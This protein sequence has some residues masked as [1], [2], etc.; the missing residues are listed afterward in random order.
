MTQDLNT[1]LTAL[2]VK[3]DDE[4]GGTRCMGRPPLLSD[5]EL[6]CLAVAQALLGHHSE[7]RWLR[8]ARKYLSGMF[9]YLPQQSGYNKRL[10]AALPLIKRMIRELAIDSDFWFDNH[11]IVDSTPV[12]CGMSR[13]TVQ[14]SNLAGW[15]GYGYCASHSRFFWGLRLYL[16]CTPTGMPILW[17]LA[18]PK[19]GEREVLAA[20]LE[21]D[22]DLVAT[23][24]GILLISDKGFAS[25]SF[26]KDL[27]ASGQGL[28]G[29]GM[30]F[31][32][33]RASAVQR[34]AV[35]ALAVPG[36]SA[37]VTVTVTVTTSASM[38]TAVLR[39][40]MP[41]GHADQSALNAPIGN[42]SRSARRERQSLV[43]AQMPGEE[44]Q[45]TVGLEGRHIPVLAGIGVQ[46]LLS[47]GQGVEQ[48][49]G[50]LA[51]HPLIVPLHQEL[52]RDGDP[53]GALGRRQRRPVQP[54]YRR[55]DPRL[56]GNQRNAESAAQRHAPVTHGAQIPERVQDRAP[57]RD[58]LGGQ[59]RV[60]LGQQRDRVARAG[61]AGPHL[62]DDP[63]VFGGLGP[64]AVGWGVDGRH[65]ETALG[66]QP[67][68]AGH[69]A[70]SLLVLSAAV[71]DE[72]QGTGFSIFRRP[73]HA[74]DLAEGE[75]SFG[76]AVGRRLRGEAHARFKPFGMPCAGAP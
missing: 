32:H 35:T 29:S 10:R 34:P 11:W 65:R 73:Q 14:R 55:A 51:R 49:Q 47:R 42:G 8:F 56:G 21:I 69:D 48:C 30:A 23:R 27:D 70:R 24:K 75:G 61:H 60:K 3:I 20:M 2:Y 6:V 40:W 38:V 25:K 18:N 57:F 67:E 19:I 28:S 46:R 12:P 74:G 31:D 43:S 4:I 62:G 7:A 72:D 22:A 33:M 66:H 63:V 59:Q 64:V 26:E 76:D 45:R 5:S 58:C 37:T 16:V 36:A 41:V 52:H 54:Q 71:S 1:V 68:G 53:G 9:P 39:M 15:A 44:P 17:A 13:P 50:L